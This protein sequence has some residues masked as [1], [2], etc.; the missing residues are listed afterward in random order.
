MGDDR[1][2]D[3][4]LAYLRRIPGIASSAIG[5]GRF[6]DGNWWVKFQIDI[7]H[8]LAWYVVQELGCVLNYLSLNERLPTVFMPVSPAPYMNGG[9]G[10]FLSWV[11]ESKDPKFKP[12]NAAKWLEGRLPRPVDDL[13]QWLRDED[14]T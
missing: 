5:K 12:G 6:D 1:D 7:R 10:A 13:S 14:G 3:S 2:F 4:L 9:P 11:I 8:E